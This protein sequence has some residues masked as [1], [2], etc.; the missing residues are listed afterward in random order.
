MMRHRQRGFTLV[1]MIIVVVIIGVLAAIA[2]PTFRKYMD[3]GRAA[4]AM[5]MLGE[6]RNREEAYRAEFGTY[7][8]TNTSAESSIFPA[9]GTCSQA[10]AVEPCVKSASQSALPPATPPAGWSALGINPQKNQLYCGYVAISGAAGTAPTGTIG[11]QQLGSANLSSPWW[12]AIA[13]C[14]NNRT[15][16]NNTT[17]ATAFNTT[18][19]ATQNEHQ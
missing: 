9:V 17:Y 10:G 5:A 1:E 16:S 3:S 6:I 8:N 4:E 18:V 2:I 19:V 13:I 12:Y 11:L 7:L 15:I 14:D